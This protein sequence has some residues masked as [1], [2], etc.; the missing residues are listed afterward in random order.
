MNPRNFKIKAK[1]LFDIGETV[2]LSNGLLGGSKL[3]VKKGDFFYHG[4]FINDF[5]KI[6]SD[7]KSYNK[8]IYYF[9]KPKYA[10]GSTVKGG[11][12][13]M[14]AKHWGTVMG[15][16]YY[17]IYLGNKR[18]SGGMTLAE[19][20][21]LAK[22][23]GVDLVEVGDEGSSL[24]RPDLEDYFRR[25]DFN[26]SQGKYA[27]GGGVGEGVKRTKTAE[28]IYEEEQQ[29]A[30][31]N[32]EYA[33]GGVIPYALRKRVEN[34][35]KKFGI[36]ITKEMGLQAYHWNT[37]GMGGSGVGWEIFGQKFSIR[38]VS[39]FNKRDSQTVGDTAIVLGE[40]YSKYGNGGMTSGWC[41]SIGG[42]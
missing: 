26:Y 12:P 18:W 20:E 34:V 37:E 5:D 42:L 3:E 23:K 28:E 24:Y 17:D 16:Q 41:Y 4:E 35:K 15:E 8:E 29:N 2:Y 7:F 11:V 13:I 31:F 9:T 32:S 14:Y 10:K 6:V 21:V 25:V 1:K 30:M 38:E 19:A 33:K 22:E 36:E 27:K 40:Y 39:R